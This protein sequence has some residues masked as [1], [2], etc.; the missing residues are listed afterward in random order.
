MKKWMVW[1]EKRKRENSSP[2]TER[3]M[4]K[5]NTNSE[6]DM[7]KKYIDTSC[8]DYVLLLVLSPLMFIMVH[9]TDSLRFT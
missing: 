2:E 4:G 6:S 1:L 7:H 5:S 8:P 3:R 9:K